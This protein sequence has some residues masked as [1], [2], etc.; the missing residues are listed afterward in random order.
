MVWLVIDLVLLCSRN[1]LTKGFSWLKIKRGKIHLIVLA[2]QTIC[3]SQ[4]RFHDFHLVLASIATV[5][6]KT[7]LGPEIA[8]CN[9]FGLI[10]MQSQS[11]ILVYEGLVL[12]YCTEM[13]T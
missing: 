13:G 11:N 5:L 9:A 10:C 8:F 7:T 3:S 2:V 6:T 4:K 1:G 12:V